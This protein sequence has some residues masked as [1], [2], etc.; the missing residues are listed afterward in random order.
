M[1]RFR[2][3]RFKFDGFYRNFPFLAPDRPYCVSAATRIAAATRIGTGI[4][5]VV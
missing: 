4:E 3:V 5:E 1:W 2:W